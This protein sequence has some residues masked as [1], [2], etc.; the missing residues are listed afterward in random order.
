MTGR[1]GGGR[2]RESQEARPDQRES[3]T[4]VTMVSVPHLGDGGVLRLHVRM[5]EPE[6]EPGPE[7]EAGQ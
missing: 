1:D 3:R 7:P 4:Y 5:K 2:D 6:P